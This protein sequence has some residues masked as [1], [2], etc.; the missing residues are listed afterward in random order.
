M[1]YFH[2]I[3]FT[4]DIVNEKFII[5]DARIKS[6]FNVRCT[7]G[8]RFRALTRSSYVLSFK[9]GIELVILHWTRSSLLYLSDRD[10]RRR[11]K[12]GKKCRK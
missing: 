12:D 10:M 8:K 11:W 4:D 5:L 6:H 2:I 3:P 9:Y 1:L 7:S